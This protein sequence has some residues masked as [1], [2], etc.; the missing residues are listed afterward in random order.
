MTTYNHER[1]LVIVAINV[2]HIT[3]V[4]VLSYQSAIAL[5][6]ANISLL[7][8][9]HCL[10]HEKDDCIMF[11]SFVNSIFSIVLAIAS[12]ASIDDSNTIINVLV[13]YV[14]VLMFCRPLIRRYTINDTGDLCMNIY[15][16]AILF[17]VVWIHVP[18]FSIICSLYIYYLSHSIYLVVRKH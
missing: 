8:Y 12:I 13:I 14:F 16:L 17:A 15:Y 1:L 5:L 18:M 2:I 7:C 10:N 6:I 3:L 9:C 4:D 11:V